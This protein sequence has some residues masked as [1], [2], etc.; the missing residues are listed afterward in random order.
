MDALLKNNS[1]IDKSGWCDLTGVVSDD[2]I[3]GSA[4]FSLEVE[5]VIDSI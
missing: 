1:L 3:Y 5:F 4:L 2:I